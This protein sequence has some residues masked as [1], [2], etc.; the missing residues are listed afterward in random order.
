MLYG[1]KYPYQLYWRCHLMILYIFTKFTSLWWRLPLLWIINATVKECAL[2]WKKTSELSMYFLLV[3]FY[4]TAYACTICLASR[5]F[6]NSHTR[7]SI[8][9]NSPRSTSNI[10]EENLIY[11]VL[12]CG[13]HEALFYNTCSLS[14]LVIYNNI[15][16]SLTKGRQ[17]WTLSAR[18]GA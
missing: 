3:P 1:L 2:P 7:I 4:A 12:K 18:L 15:P 14:W 9:I 10:C 13:Q 8:R 16:E 17:G 11:I 6:S 5:F